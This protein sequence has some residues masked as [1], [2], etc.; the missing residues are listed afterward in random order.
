[1]RG[2]DQRDF[3]QL[4]SVEHSFHGARR[5]SAPP[6]HPDGEDETFGLAGLLHLLGFGDVVG[7]RLFDEDVFARVKRSHR[8]LVV[9]EVRRRQQYR[10]DGFVCQYGVVGVVDAPAVLFGDCGG[11][12]GIA[13]INASEGELVR[14]SGGVEQQPPPTRRG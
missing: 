2:N 11:V 8:L 3:P 14:K 12:L 7:N 6:L 1:M 9:E 13:A 4:T 10:F 5:A